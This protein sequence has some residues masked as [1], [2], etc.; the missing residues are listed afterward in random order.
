MDQ[1]I[2]TLELARIYE[3]QGYFRTAQKIYAFLDEQNTSTEIRAG[4][5][6]CEKKMI[7]N[8]SAENPLKENYSQDDLITDIKS[9]NF[10]PEDRRTGVDSKKKIPLLLE[11]WL[12]L[13]VLQRRLS[14]YKKNQAGLI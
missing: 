12:M 7:P 8:E 14:K 1:D 13:M 3:S 4:L 9:V 5:K 2:N 11:K 10:Q 6:R